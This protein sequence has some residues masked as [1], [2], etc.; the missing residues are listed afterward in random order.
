MNL[1]YAALRPEVQPAG[2]GA[3]TVPFSDLVPGLSVFDATKPEQTFLNSKNEPKE[4]ESLSK[5]QSHP[6]VHPLAGASLT[7]SPDRQDPHL[8]AWESGVQA[9]SS[10]PGA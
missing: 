9:K 2:R 3:D 5:N 8:F 6:S 10:E 7:Q 4:A 1:G